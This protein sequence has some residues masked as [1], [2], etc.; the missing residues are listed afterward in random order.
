MKQ[1]VQLLDLPSLGKMQNNYIIAPLQKK[2]LD[3][4]NQ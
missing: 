3:M 1:Y 4:I 2:N